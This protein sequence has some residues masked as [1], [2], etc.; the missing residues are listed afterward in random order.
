M[1]ILQVTPRYPPQSGG[2]EIHVQKISQGLARLGHTVTVLTADAGLEVS[3][4]EQ[5]DDIKV[6]RLRSFAPNH[7]IHLCPQ[8]STFVRNTDADIVHA[9]NYHSLPLFFAA[10]GINDQRFFVTPH[11]HGGSA[12]RIRDSLLTLYHKFGRWAL[13]QADQIIAVSDWEQKQLQIDFDIE[14]R[15]IPNGI[16]VYRFSEAEPETRERPYLLCVGRLEEYKGIQHLIRALPELPT[17]ELVVVGSGS[18]RKELERITAESGVTDRVTF[19]GYVDDCRLPKLYSG[20]ATYVTLSEFEA[21]GIT[22]GESLAAGT[23]C[24]VRERGA[25]TDWTKYKG[26]VGVKEPTIES[27]CNAVKCCLDSDPVVDLPSWEEIANQTETT[28]LESNFD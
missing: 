13:Q 17:Y 26:C 7:S 8:I 5:R 3:Q 15:V 27:I 9:H 4:N 6:R 16:D 22:V 25:L 20:A 14:P 2:V 1:N 11:Y 12:N 19:L 28:Y 24:V 10:L 18:Y 21:Y 23:P